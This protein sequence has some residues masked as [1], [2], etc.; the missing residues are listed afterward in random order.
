L[1]TPA[2][3]RTFLSN[4]PYVRNVTSPGATSMQKPLP[5]VPKAHAEKLMQLLEDGSDDQD[6]VARLTNAPLWQSPSME[7]LR[8]APVDRPKLSDIRFNM[9]PVRDEM[10]T[11]PQAPDNVTDYFSAISPQPAEAVSLSDVSID[12]HD[13]L[14]S[15]ANQ[16][17]D[18]FALP[19]AQ[20]LIAIFDFGE[21]NS[22]LRESAALL[23][24]RHLLQPEKT[25]D[26]YVALV[27]YLSCL[28]MD[29]FMDYL[30]QMD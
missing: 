14:G 7:R 6:A 22:V 15:S 1:F 29:L 11:P 18:S 25:C 3:L 8:A 24:L 4:K 16:A 17:S 28:F 21:H 10:S 30:W 20:L 12:T 26:V 9:T 23:S 27:L 2:Q 5:P 13:V 19:L